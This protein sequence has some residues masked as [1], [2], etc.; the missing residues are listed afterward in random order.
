MQES[1]NAE[2]LD[3]A[4]QRYQDLLQEVDRVII[5]QDDVVQ[6][7]VTALDARERCLLIGV[8]RLAKTR[9]DN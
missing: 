9:L 7:L 4:K 2:L 3:T 5:G 6:N 1:D 8:P